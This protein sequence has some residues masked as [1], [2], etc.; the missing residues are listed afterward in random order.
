MFGFGNN[1]DQQRLWNL[2][3]FGFYGTDKEFENASPWIFGAALIIGGIV[4]LCYF[5]G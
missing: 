1:D 2:A 5:F 4:A 3:V